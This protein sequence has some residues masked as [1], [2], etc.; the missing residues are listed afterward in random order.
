MAKG[1]TIP[2]MFGQLTDLVN[3]GFTAPADILSI[4]ATGQ[5]DSSDPYADMLDIGGQKGTQGSVYDEVMRTTGDPMLANMAASESVTDGLVQA[6]VN[7]LSPSP[8]KLK[9]EQAARD[10]ASANASIGYTESGDQGMLYNTT[11]EQVA[12]AY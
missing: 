10:V 2:E 1:F 4:A 9:L 3:Q 8:Q 7:D 11:V 12:K 5:P 6:K